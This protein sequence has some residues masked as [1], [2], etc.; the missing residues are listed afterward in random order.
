MECIHSKI[1]ISVSDDY[2]QES[3]SVLPALVALLTPV[4]SDCS[5]LRYFPAF[6]PSFTVSLGLSQKPH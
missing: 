5:H 2:T 4:I 6:S 3:I 1:F